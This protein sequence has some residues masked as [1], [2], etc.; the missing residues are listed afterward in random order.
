MGLRSSLSVLVAG[1]VFAAA[2][3]LC[4]QLAGLGADGSSVAA[5]VLAIVAFGLTLR[6]TRPERRGI[7]D[8]RSVH[9]RSAALGWRAD[10]QLRGPFVVPTERPDERGRELPE[11]PGITGRSSPAGRDVPARE[12]V[13]TV[14]TQDIQFIVDDA[15]M[16]VLGRRSTVRGELWEEH[17]RIRWSAVT[18]VGFATGRHDWR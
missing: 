1:A 7:P 11:N 4:D 5:D 12:R 6:V 15:G 18:A 3:A 8:L 2:W 14:V 9:A 16:Q 10:T 17:L 13:R